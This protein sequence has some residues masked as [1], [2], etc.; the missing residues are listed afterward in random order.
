MHEL[1][2]VAQTADHVPAWLAGIVSALG[3]TGFL[4]WFGW[5]MTSKTIPTIVADFRAEMKA[6][7][8]ANDARESKLLAVVGDQ[9][10]VNHEDS[11]RLRDA[12]HGL[13]MAI[14][15][16]GLPVSDMDK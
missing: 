2:L 4:A 9:Q 1:I 12:L 7:R 3:G 5:Y 6:E 8:E 16:S 15:K 10:R 13:K 14:Q 11:V